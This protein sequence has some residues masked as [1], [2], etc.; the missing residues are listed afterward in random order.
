MK[1]PKLKTI[2]IAIAGF[3]IP[4]LVIFL[5]I[6]VYTQQYNNY[7]LTGYHEY[8]WV[9][10]IDVQICFPVL[11]FFGIIL[12]GA[13]ITGLASRRPIVGFLSGAL[14]IPELLVGSSIAQYT[15]PSTTFTTYNEALDFLNAHTYNGYLALLTHWNG[16]ISFGYGTNFIVSPYLYN[17][18]QFLSTYVLSCLLCGSVGIIGAIIKKK[19]IKGLK[20]VGAWL[21]KEKK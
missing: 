21:I 7:E 14:L 2:L 16:V 1:K 9:V 17:I 5:L 12:I 6:P 18:F 3:T 4:A 13:F 11:L 15:A 10:T 8:N 20:A 19:H